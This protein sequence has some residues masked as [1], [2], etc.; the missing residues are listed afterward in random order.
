MIGKLVGP[1][2]PNPEI[3]S[4]CDGTLGFDF[5]SGGYVLTNLSGPNKLLITRT[6]DLNRARQALFRATFLFPSYTPL[7]SQLKNKAEDLLLFNC[8]CKGG[9]GH[10]M[11]ERKGKVA[12][13]RAWQIVF[14]KKKRNVQRDIM[15]ITKSC[16]MS[17]PIR[18]KGYWQM[19]LYFR[20]ASAIYDNP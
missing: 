1:E 8:G 7:Y 19:R 15:G 14:R 20:L 13:N 5:G 12:L 18:Y 11:C 4:R 3:C 17:C 9:N 2:I 10:G 16:Y 6:V